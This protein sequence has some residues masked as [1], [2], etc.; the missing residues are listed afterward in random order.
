M[1]Q[2]LAA[3]VFI[4]RACHQ[5]Y[6]QMRVADHD[7]AESRQTFGIGGELPEPVHV[8]RAPVEHA[9]LAWGGEENQAV[10]EHHSGR[11]PIRS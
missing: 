11:F 6:G 10:V 7:L 8:S 4:H 1:R 9:Y 3:I 5:Q 2:I